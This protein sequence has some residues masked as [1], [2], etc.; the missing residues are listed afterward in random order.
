MKDGAI[1]CN[2]GHFDDEIDVASIRDLPWEEV[3]PQVHEIVFSQ[4]KN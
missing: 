1:L 4:G 3:K 2:I